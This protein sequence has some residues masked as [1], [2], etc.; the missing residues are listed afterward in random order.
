MGCCGSK[1]QSQCVMS[2]LLLLKNKTN[3]RKYQY[4]KA[5]NKHL[6]KAMANEVYGGSV[7]L[8][9]G[10]KGKK[11]TKANPLYDEIVSMEAKV[12]NEPV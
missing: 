3:I 1:I 10:Q 11:R 6:E 2:F 7:L 12:D 9:V 8:P 4:N 5:T